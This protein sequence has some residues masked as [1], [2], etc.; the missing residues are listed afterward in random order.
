MGQYVVLGAPCAVPVTP[1]A[2]RYPAAP[3]PTRE[4]KIFGVAILPH[5]DDYPSRTTQAGPTPNLQDEIFGLHND[6]VHE[7]TPA[8][9][10]GAF[11]TLVLPVGASDW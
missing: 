3:T 11:G 5:S 10:T 9:V 1:L 4:K 8:A 2:M 6:P 7:K